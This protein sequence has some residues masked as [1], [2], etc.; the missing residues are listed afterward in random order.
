MVSIPSSSTVV[1]FLVIIPLV[2]PTTTGI[3]KVLKVDPPP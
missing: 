2:E 1:T 3:T